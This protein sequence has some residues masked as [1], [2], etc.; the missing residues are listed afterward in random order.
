MKQEPDVV[1]VKYV[2]PN[3]VVVF[4]RSVRAHESVLDVAY[5]NAPLYGI[6]ILGWSKMF[7]AFHELHLKIS[8]AVEER[9]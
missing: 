8:L 3:T 1:Q 6:Q 7:G 4:V 5:D 2:D 9:P